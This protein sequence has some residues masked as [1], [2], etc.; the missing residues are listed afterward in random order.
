[1]SKLMKLTFSHSSNV[2]S[3]IYWSDMRCK[4]MSIILTWQIVYVEYFVD[5]LFIYFY[6]N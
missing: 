4:D 2:T 3:L 6:E 5:D 1:M